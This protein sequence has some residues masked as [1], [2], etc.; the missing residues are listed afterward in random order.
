MTSLWELARNSL[1]VALLNF[2]PASS[3]GKALAERLKATAKT[4]IEVEMI[5]QALPQS[6]LSPET[7]TFLDTYIPVNNWSFLSIMTYS[8]SFHRLCL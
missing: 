1:T 4:G 6:R 3:A 8:P 2:K 7:L 5:T